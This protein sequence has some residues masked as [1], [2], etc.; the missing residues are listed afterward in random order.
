MSVCNVMIV[1]WSLRIIKVFCVRHLE[2]L[3][4]L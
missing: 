1:L 4:L 2:H 3:Y